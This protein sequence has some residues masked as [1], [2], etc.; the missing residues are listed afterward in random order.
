[1]RKYRS[2][3]IFFLTLLLVACGSSPSIDGNV[4]QKNASKEPNIQPAA[5]EKSAS[6]EEKAEET[7]VIV[8]SPKAGSMVKSPLSI[9]GSAPGTWFFEASLPVRILDANGQE[10][11]IGPAQAEGEWM[12][13][14]PVPFSVTLSFTP[15]TA[16]GT[17]VVSKDNPSGLPE[18]DASFTVP[19]QFSL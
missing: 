12:T 5:M 15:T 4:P 13:R 1:M 16:T 9:Q 18:H 8:M 17:I 19:I 10:I 6:M 2:S 3:S 7:G 11:A 14:G